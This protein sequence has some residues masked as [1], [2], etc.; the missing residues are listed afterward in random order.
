[1]LPD[2]LEVIHQPARLA[3]MTLLYQRGDVGAP[4]ARE[5]TGLTPGNLDGHAKKLAEAGL[6]EGRR[7]LTRDGFEVRYHL[8]A[9]GLNAMAAYLDWLETFAVNLKAGRRPAAGDPVQGSV[10][11]RGGTRT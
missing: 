3:L 9:A 2:G 10:A 5:A 11:T 6:L 8:T 1:M 4:A 7:S